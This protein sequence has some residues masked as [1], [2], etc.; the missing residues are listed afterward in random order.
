MLTD[1]HR[2]RTALRVLA[3]VNDHTDP[4]RSDV[5]RLKAWV[6]PAERKAAV[7]GKPA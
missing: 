5:E 4:V 7:D 6:A 3:Q 1:N 2:L